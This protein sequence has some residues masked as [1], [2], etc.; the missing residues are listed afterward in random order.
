M[1]L[2]GVLRDALLG[3][4]VLNLDPLV[5]LKLDDFAS[6]LVF[7]EG[8]VASEFLSDRTRSAWV[9]HGNRQTAPIHWAPRRQGERTF[10][11]ALRSFLESY[12]R[13]WMTGAIKLLKKGKVVL[14]RAHPWGDP[15][16][17]S[18][19]CGHFVV[20]YGCE[21]SSAGF[22]RPHHQVAVLRLQK[23]LYI[24]ERW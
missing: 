19:F 7:D 16:R 11:K 9:E 20:G 22:L 1:Q 10:L 17:W 3:Q 15:A 23:G 12:S 4:E 2:D 18:T 6:L 21:Y 5:A 14:K 8:T 13:R 24:W